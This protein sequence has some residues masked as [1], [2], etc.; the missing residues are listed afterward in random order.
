MHMRK[1]LPC[2]IA[3]GIVALA[4]C[5]KEGGPGA[6]GPGVVAPDDP[7]TYV[8]ADT[9][10]VIA[11]ID[12][13]PKEVSDEWIAKLDK[14]GK[15][16]DVYAQ[17]LTG[18]LDD[19]AK[20]NANCAAAA[21]SGGGGGALQDAPAAESEATEAPAVA[22]GD[23]GAQPADGSPA[24]VADASAA[25]AADDKCSAT[26][27]A[28]REKATKILGAIKDEVAGKDI[29][30][31]MDLLGV[32]PQT[33]AAFYGIGL[34]PVLRLE[35]DKPD[36]LRATI[37]RIE[38]KSTK[39]DTAKVGNLTY[40]VIRGDSDK[41]KLE[42]VIAISGKQLVATIAPAKASDADLKTLFGIDKPAKSLASSGDLQAMNK[43]MNY[44]SY[45]SGYF[46]SAKLVAE[47]KAAPTPL[48]TSFL[49]AIG[50]KKPQIDPVCAGEYDHLAATW[51]R[52]SFG[53][54]DLSAKHM[55]L[56]A[57]IEARPDI[58]KDLMSLR[59]P[60]PGLDA[61]KTA[62]VD[63]G[64]SVNLAKLPDLATKYAEAVSKSPWKCPNL[65]GLN[66]SAEK[67]KT[68]LTNPGFAGYT[69]MFHGLHVIA[70]KVEV[71]DDKPIPDIAAVAVIGSD[72]PT[73]ILAM[74]GNF[75]PGLANIGLKPDG[76]PKALPAM[77]N[78]PIQA[79]IFA[80][81]SDKALAISL[82]AGEE[83]R[84]A[85]AMK[86]DATQQPLFAGGARGEFYTVLASFMRKSAQSMPDGSQSRQML[87]QQAKMMD[88]YAGLFKRAEVSV[89]LTE[90]GIEFH[91][92]VDMQ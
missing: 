53:Y 64:F 26:S 43:K 21:S 38:T 57:V 3:A 82:G 58:A 81:M 39:L 13:Q 77:P 27:V 12:P 18:L 40:W 72:N 4:G 45:G 66:D 19:L 24:T 83:T 80:A 51:P 11:N 48:E 20:D 41:A 22:P 10:Y 50:E 75:L 34:V 65:V 15:V 69:G 28:G 79:P 49:T 23:D 2:L 44:L 14:A 29:K 36:N 32:S 55:A 42:G 62:L 89:E 1:V 63:F 37:G 47:L 90:Q 74:A 71:K 91:E 9:P 35:L 60:M 54:S 76:T 73:S 17:Q 59:A 70:D 84:I 25:P 7:L 52:A 87:E 5:H 67:A 68:T 88:T 8:P 31:L 86:T 46:D 61:A 30:G 6:S 33:H 56:R 85:A 92:S 16:G 78:L